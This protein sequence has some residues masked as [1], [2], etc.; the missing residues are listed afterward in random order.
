MIL[1][2]ILAS[3]GA[4]GAV[5]PSF[6]TSAPL[7][8]DASDSATITQSSGSV[9]Q[10]D[11][12]GTLENFVQVT[13]AS[14][15]T[16]NATTLNGLN[17]IDFAADFMNGQTLANWKFMHDGTKYFIASVVKYG[18]SANPDTVF[19]LMGTSSFRS[20]NIGAYFVYDDRSSS[21]RTDRAVW[22]IFRGVSASIAVAAEADNFITPNEFSVQ[23]ALLDPSNATAADRIDYYSD[24]TQGTADNT[25][26]AS[27]SSSNPSYTIQLGAGGN[28]EFPLTGSIAELI[29]VSGTDA[30]E[31]N[32]QAT[33]DYLNTKWSVF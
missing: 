3:A 18:V 12:K 8:L 31:T 16:T 2:G 19:S 13:G 24:G 7:W 23:S 5:A 28:S 15:P 27:P 20:A 32:R 30:T 17:V 25:R 29:V 6:L 14:Q 22:I 4:G 1:L 9:S 21:S 26:T 33:V 11:N 10:W